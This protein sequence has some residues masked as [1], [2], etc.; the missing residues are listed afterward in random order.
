MDAPATMWERLRAARIATAAVVVTGALVGL[1]ASV[2]GSPFTPPLF[3]GARAPGILEGAAGLI[4]LDALSREGLAVLGAAALFAAAGA[5]L[6]ALGAAWRGHLSARRVIVVGILL[7]LLALAIPLFLSRDVYSYAIYGRMVSQHGA[8]PYTD[9]PAAFADDDVYPLVSVDWIDSRSVYGPAFTAVSAGVTSLTSSPASTVFG[10]KALAAAAGVLTML[11]TVAAARRAAPERVAFAAALVGWNPVIVFHGVAGG[12]NDA[13]VGLAVAAAVLLVL[14]R[15]EMLATVA[16]TVGTLVKISAAVPLLVAAVAFVFR[17]PQGRRVVELLK[18]AGVAVL[19]ALPFVIPFMQAED[20]TLGTLELTSRQGWLAPSR[21]VLVTLRGAAN[22]IGGE[23]AGDVVSVVVRLAFPLAFVWV[24][25]VLLRHL[26]R[27]RDGLDTVVV[28]GAMGWASLISLM[29]SPVL[30]PWYVAWLIPLAWILPRTARGGAVLI[31]VALAI[32]ELVA[33]P[34]RAPRVWEAMVFGL[35]WVAT[36]IILLVLIR[37]LLDLRR[38]TSL[39]PAEGFDDPLLADDS[40]PP[41]DGSAGGEPAL[42]AAPAGPG[43][44]HMAGHAE[45]GDERQRAGPA[46]AEAD[47]VGDE[48]SQDRRGDPD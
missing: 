26:I 27:A 47:P 23:V 40:P 24:L 31:S 25:V 38:R 21:F 20:P 12:H 16:L 15:R 32:T 41:G 46:G 35:H 1:V 6:Y 29:V 33:E 43:G 5:F 3:P 36:P 9:I 39:P 42:V 30:L 19:V 17:R 44:G 13:L 45:R 2:P 8:N 18:H 34:S 4:G 10:F 37:L 7:H 28:L 22:A 14:V 11:V 48:G